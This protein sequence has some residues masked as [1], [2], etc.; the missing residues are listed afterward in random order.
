MIHVPVCVWQADLTAVEAEWTAADFNPQR[1]KTILFAGRLV[2]RKRAHDLITAFARLTAAF[3]EWR[4]EIRGLPASAA[5]EAQLYQ[6]INQ[7]QLAAKAA[8]RPPLSGAALYRRYRETAVY[9]LPSEGEGMP[10]T[11]LEAMYFGGAIVAGIS[12]AVSYQLADG[13][14]GLLHHPGDIDGLT[15][16]L[17]TLMTSEAERDGYRE[18]ARARLLDLFVW[19]R[20]LPELTQAFRRAL[21]TAV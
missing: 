10:S 9:A 4:L 3:P 13:R 16:H 7:H 20:Y 18:R 19:E 11:I 5:Y 8:I 2:A 21:G 14:C 15:S 17:Q 1:E 6:L 12:G